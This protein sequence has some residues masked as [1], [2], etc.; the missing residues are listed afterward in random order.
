MPFEPTGTMN[1]DTSSTTASTGYKFAAVVVT[2]NR[3]TLLVE[4]LDAL[5][6]QSHPLDA[7]FVIDQSSSDGTPELLQESGYLQNPVIH[8]ER[9]KNNTGGAGGFHRGMER[10]YQAGYDWIWIM[11]DD[12]VA[13]SEALAQMLPFLSEAD[14]V[15]IANV[16]MSVTG[17]ADEN[18]IIRSRSQNSSPLNSTAITFSSFV[19]LMVSRRAIK[20]IGLPK[21]EFFIYLDDTEYCMRLQSA[22]RILLAEKS[23]IIHKEIARSVKSVRHFGMNIPIYSTKDFIFRDYIGTRNRIW[24]ETRLSNH[25]VHGF[26]DI[27]KDLWFA[28]LRILFVDRTVLLTRMHV[29]LRAVI[30]GVTGNFDND[31]AF[32]MRDKIDKSNN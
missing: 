31:F 26:I 19:G 18:H 25:K 3:K 30:D 2:F 16:K 20:S 24:M 5:L 17:I 14:T 6:R 10:A 13:D 12:A 7:I 1:S 29:C 28:L 21:A 32:R 23:I 27:G 11:D 9:S 4:C 22:G 15:A 8:Y